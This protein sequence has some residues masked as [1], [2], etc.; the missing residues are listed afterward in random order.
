MKASK[1]QSQPQIAAAAFLILC[2]VL[3]R[4]FSCRVLIMPQLSYV[5][6][7]EDQNNK[8]PLK[9]LDHS[10]SPVCPETV[11]PQPKK[12]RLFEAAIEQ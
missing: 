7:P 3:G 11:P 6:S 9:T 5:P 10:G 12:E 2:M 4:S 8:S 1:G